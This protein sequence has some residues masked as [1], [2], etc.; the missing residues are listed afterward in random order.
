MSRHIYVWEC[1][2]CGWKQLTDAIESDYYD[3]SVYETPEGWY[4]L[5]PLGKVTSGDPG[6]YKADHICPRCYEKLFGSE[7]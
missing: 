2:A 3:L 5:T 6:E 1:S 4:E 7:S